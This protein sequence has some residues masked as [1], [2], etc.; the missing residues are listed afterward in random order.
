M[1]MMNKVGSGKNN[2]AA[3]HNGRLILQSLVMVVVILIVLEVVLKLVNLKFY[4]RVYDLAVYQMKYMDVPIETIVEKDIVIPQA[5]LH[6]K[7]E[8]EYPYQPDTKL[9]WRLKPNFEYGLGSIKGKPGT[10]MDLHTNV[11]GMRDRHYSAQKAPDTFRIICLGDSSTFGFGIGIMDEDPYPQRLEAILNEKYPLRHIEVFNCGVPG[12]TV[13]Q[14]LQWLKNEL[15][16]FEP[17]A[18][19]VSFG[20]NDSLKAKITDVERIKASSSFFGLMKHRLNRFE[21]YKLLKY[22]IMEIRLAMIRRNTEVGTLKPKPMRLE[23]QKIIRGDQEE[24]VQ[25]V[26]AGKGKSIE[27]KWVRRVKKAELR[28]SYHRLI[29]LLKENDI[30]AI[31]F[32]PCMLQQACDYVSPQ[33]LS[34]ADQFDINLVQMKQILIDEKVTERLLQLDRVHPTVLGHIA[35]AKSLASVVKSLDNFRRYLEDEPA[36][37]APQAQG[38]KRV[39]DLHP[40]R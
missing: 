1:W 33:L 11:Y 29:E 26:P 36:W 20:H 6:P 21:L 10:I 37:L 28:D 17:D 16:Y 32:D 27:V 38:K 3:L 35:I 39:I 34:I 5:F 40:R 13:V 19:I 30:D 25:T 24:G 14:G 23:A 12:Y 9:L 8:S 31:I 15:L 7:L 4:Q 2:D 22:C 18:V